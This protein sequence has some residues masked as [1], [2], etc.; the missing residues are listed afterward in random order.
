MKNLYSQLNSLLP[1]HNPKCQKLP[2]KPSCVASV[3]LETKLKMAQEKKERLFE[4]KK[5]LSGCTLNAS[6][7][8]AKMEVH[9]TGSAI[10]VILTC[11]IGNNF[12]FC[13]ILR[14]LS[15]LNVEVVTVN[16]TMVGDSMVHAVQGEVAQSMFQFGDSTVSEKLKWFVNGSFSDMEI[17]LGLWD[18]GIGLPLITPGCCFLDPTLDTGLPSYPC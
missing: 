3:S 11:G 12:I 15:E 2:T 17:D 1:S 9:E 14:I 13:E 5:T 18:S 7:A 6:E 10:Q 16:S 4:K 8:Q